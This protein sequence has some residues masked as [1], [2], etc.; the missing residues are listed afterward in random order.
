VV[1]APP[2]RSL[3]DMMAEG[4]LDAG[5]HAN[6]GIGRTGS[7]TEG[8]KAAPTNYPD[9]FPNAEELEAD[10]FRRTGIYPMHGTSVVKD[11][12]LAQYPWV[13]QS[14]YQAFSRAKD[15]WLARLDAG[16]AKSES[17]RKYVRLRN[18]VGHDP[19]PFGMQANRKTLEA[20][21]DTAHKQQL[22][23]TRMSL[24]ALFV[25]PERH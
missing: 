21:A 11:S 2:G 8:W 7:P 3:A 10:W 15:E 17:D 24:D 23:P 12:V 14:L 18:I 1:H 25:D 6:A 4:E 9:L 22:T 16:D 13:A 20:L 5:F 19:L